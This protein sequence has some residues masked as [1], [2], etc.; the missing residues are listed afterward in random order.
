MQARQGT[1][2]NRRARENAAD[3]GRGPVL[4]DPMLGEHS[5][6]YNT[7]QYSA[8]QAADRCAAV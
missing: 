6:E 4:P 8:V 3:G 5:R 2:A 7:V 1:E